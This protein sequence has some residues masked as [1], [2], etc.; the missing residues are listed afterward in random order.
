MPNR[1]IL[2]VDNE[3]LGL[4]ALQSVLS[5]QFYFEDL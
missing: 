5:D 1:P 2:I 3:L 4:A